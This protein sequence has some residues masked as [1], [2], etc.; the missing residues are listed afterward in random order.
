MSPKENDVGYILKNNIYKQ[1]G[2]IRFSLNYSHIYIKEKK[3]M[4][5]EKRKE[6]KVIYMMVHPP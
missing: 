1:F 4:V 2:T 3:D 6:K 5:K